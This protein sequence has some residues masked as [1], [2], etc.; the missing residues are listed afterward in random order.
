MSISNV[1]VQSLTAYQT[2][3]SAIAAD[4]IDTADG[5]YID[6][7]GVK[8]SQLLILIESTSTDVIVTFEAGDDFSDNGIGDLDVTSITG[9][10]GIVL[11]SARFKDEDERII[12]STTTTGNTAVGGCTLRAVELP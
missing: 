1:V 4:P 6:V 10:A 3:T 11:E 9:I 2:L 5:N 12:I 7:S 8:T